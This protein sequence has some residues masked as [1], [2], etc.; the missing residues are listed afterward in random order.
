MGASIYTSAMVL[1]Y[2]A[3]AIPTLDRLESESDIKGQNIPHFD[4]GEMPSTIVAYGNFLLVANFGSDTISA[5][6]V[7]TLEVSSIPVGNGPIDIE[8]DPFKDILYVANFDSGTISAI[9]VD[10]SEVSSIPVGNGPAELEIEPLENKAYVVNQ[11]SKTVS[12]INTSNY[13]DKMDIPVGDGP[14]DI[15]VDD[16][17]VY[18]ANVDTVS[19]IDLNTK[20]VSNIPVGNGPVDIEINLDEDII[21]VVNHYSNSLSVIYGKTHQVQAG[22]SFDINPFHAGRIECNDVTVPTNKYFYA[23]FRTK[24]TA[25]ANPGFQFSNW[26]ENLGSNSSRTIQASQGDWFTNTLDWLNSTFSGK[27]MVTPAT[28][29]VTKFGNFTANFEKLPPAIPPGYLATLFAVVASAFIGSWL[30][31]G[32]IGWRRAKKQGNKLDYYY[33]KDKTFVCRWQIG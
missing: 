16:E 6:D 14:I 17:I 18:V 15:E 21:Y 8:E 12:V 30:T 2:N 25:Q 3:A 5:I 22:V 23:D 1:P 9:D 29:N 7:D 33:E 11:F 26:I 10:T 28:L 31:P 27:P 4:V 32:F 24:C 13:T 20:K 19:V